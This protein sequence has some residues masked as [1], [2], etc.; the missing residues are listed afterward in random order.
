[1]NFPEE[2][3]P[4]VR[5]AVTKIRL[6][7]KAAGIWKFAAGLHTQDVK[8]VYADGTVKD[9]SL[10]PGVPHLG[11]FTVVEVENIEEAYKWAQKIAVGCRCPQEVK[12]LIYAPH[13]DQE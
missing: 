7:G 11:G 12:E 2:D 8:T 5:D 1:M 9:S 3:F 6:D 10:Q 13:E 4:A